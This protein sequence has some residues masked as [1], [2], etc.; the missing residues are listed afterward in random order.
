[1]IRIL[2]DLDDRCQVFLV[3]IYP[4]FPSMGKQ[5]IFVTSPGYS[6]LWRIQKCKTQF[7]SLGNLKC[8]KKNKIKMQEI[9][10]NNGLQNETGAQ[11]YLFWAVGIGAQQRMRSL[12][13][14]SKREDLK[15]DLHGLVRLTQEE[16]LAFRQRKHLHRHGGANEL[17]MF[18]VQ[19]MVPPPVP[20]L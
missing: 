5:K 14:A 2:R 13:N 19:K 16:G 17:G 6:L 11:M 18:L 3:C 1:M 20:P 10:S 4:A 12:W 8:N 9:I 7:N 15:L